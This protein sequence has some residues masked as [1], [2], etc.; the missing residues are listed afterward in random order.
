MKYNYIT[1]NKKVWSLRNEITKT[2]FW[3]H[4]PIN[5][6]RNRDNILISIKE[7]ITNDFI[8]LSVKSEVK[9]NKIHWF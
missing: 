5:N 1:K 3:N 9:Q 4:K 7:K 2:F 6:I 8:Y